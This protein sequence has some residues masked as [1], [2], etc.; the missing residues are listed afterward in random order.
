MQMLHQLG[1]LWLCGADIVHHAC[2][3]GFVCKSAMLPTG[4]AEGVRMI[5][6]QLEQRLHLQ[7]WWRA[8]SGT[9]A[10]LPSP[11]CTKDTTLRLPVHRHAQT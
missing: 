8:S 5:E 1:S 4:D 2:T 9:P 3:Q 7:S 10:A 6:W 11:S